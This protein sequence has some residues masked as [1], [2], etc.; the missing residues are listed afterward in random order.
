MLILHL[1][2]TGPSSVKRKASDSLRGPTAL[3]VPK[4]ATT[5]HSP[6]LTPTNEGAAAHSPVMD[7][8]DDLMS[9]MSSQ[10]EPD[11]DD[12]AILDSDDGSLGQ[13]K[14]QDSF[15]FCGVT[16]SYQYYSC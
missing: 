4:Q 12:E 9:D 1:A 11:F 15:Q 2:I 14:P 5:I 3:K 6:A 13:G 10:I 8:D 7:S 16:S